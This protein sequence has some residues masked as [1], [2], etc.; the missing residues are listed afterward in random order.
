MK[1]RWKFPDHD[2]IAQE[3][4]RV[5]KG[6]SMSRGEEIDS[7][8]LLQVKVKNNKAQCLSVKFIRFWN[9]TLTVDP[10]SFYC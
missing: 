10:L 9:G 1:H 8:G 6:L 4:V 7:S 2:D 3:S 5:A